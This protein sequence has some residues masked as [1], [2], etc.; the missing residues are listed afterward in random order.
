MIKH[1][2]VA[3]AFPAMGWLAPACLWGQ[4]PAV[5]GAATLYT[6]VTP[7]TLELKAEGLMTSLDNAGQAG[8]LLE[9]AGRMLAVEDANS[10][11]LLIRAA[12]LHYFNG[13]LAQARQAMKD[14]GWRALG[15]GFP[16]AAANAYTDAALIA[17]AQKD[18]DGARELAAIV[19]LIAHWPGL[20]TAERRQIKS[21]IK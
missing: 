10:V 19:N 6:E 11:G 4:V 16:V 14:A 3:A 12:R 17:V 15:Q 8:D 18:V 7:A 9:Q 5:T 2:M 20:T 13:E 21:R 1:M